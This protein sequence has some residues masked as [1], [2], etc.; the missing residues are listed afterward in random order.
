MT[1]T[2]PP[3]T[4]GIEEEYH[5]VDLETRDLRAAPPGFMEACQ[6]Q[7]GDRVSPE[8]AR[9]EVDEVVFLLDAERKGG[10]GAG[11]GPESGTRFPLPP[12]LKRYLAG[13]SGCYE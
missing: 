9:F 3:F 12:D 7:L 6:R 1:S 5:L 2:L 8:V 11:H 4:F 10:K 13:T